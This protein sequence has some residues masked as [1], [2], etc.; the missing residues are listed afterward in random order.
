MGDLSLSSVSELR[1]GFSRREGGDFILCFSKLFSRPD[2][3]RALFYFFMV[4]FYF[5]F[6]LF[7]PRSVMDGRGFLLRGTPSGNRGTPK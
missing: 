1:L 6:I 3:G 5:S 7:S 2:G 4:R